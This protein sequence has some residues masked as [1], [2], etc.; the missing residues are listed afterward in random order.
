MDI[1]AA[2]II[3]AKAVLRAQETITVDRVAG[4]TL[5]GTALASTV[6]ETDIRLGGKTVI[7]TLSSASWVENI[8][9]DTTIKNALF[10]GFVADVENDIQWAKVVS[11]LKKTPGCVTKTSTNSI[12]ITL[13]KVYAYDITAAKQNISVTIP[14]GAAIGTT[15]NIQA[16]NA[17]SINSTPPTAAKI[18]EVKAATKI[19]KSGDIVDINVTFDTPVDVL[20]IQVDDTGIPAINLET[21]TIDRNAVYSSGTGTNVLTFSYTV[22]DGDSSLKLD[23]K[24]KDSLV[25]LGGNI[26][27]MGTS[28]KAV[29]TLPVPGS[30]GSLSDTSVV[31]VDAVAPKFNTS[32]PKKGTITE[33]TA[34][35]LINVNEKAT[36]YYVTRINDINN[37]PSVAQVITEGQ[38]ATLPTTMA[39]KLDIVGNIDGKLPLSGLTA[40]KDYTVYMVM[41]D[42]LGNTSSTVNAFNFSTLDTTP[43]EFS[44][45]DSLDPINYPIQ[46]VPTSD[47]L[48]NILIKTNET[49]K[50]YLIAVPNGSTPPTSTQVMAFHNAN[51]VPISQYLK[52]T[53]AITKDTQIILGVT[54]L[55]V[56][57][58]YDIYVVCVDAIGNFI[59]NPAKVTASTSQ[60]S[61]KNV[62]VDLAKKI[63]TNTTVQMQYSFDEQNWFDCTATNTNITYD[64]NAAILA[65]FIR[66]TKNIANTW[67]LQAVKR[68]D[69]ANIN[70][71]A[72]SYDIAAKT[73]T[74]TSTINLQYR[75]DGGAWN[76]LNA[77]GNASNVDF[78]PG[79]LEV[80]TAVTVS[81]LPSLP[82]T[83]YNIA[84]P[85]PAPN[86][87]YDDSE[88]IIIGLDSTYEFSIDGGLWKTIVVDGAFAGT[89]KVE[90][91]QKAT[92]DKL[93]SIAKVI[94]FT[95]G[96][97]KVVAVPAAANETSFMSSVTITF[98]ENTNKKA[99]TPKDIRDYFLVGTWSTTSGAIVASHYWGADS[100]FKAQWNTA[101]NVLTII[102]STM[103][104]STVKINDEVRIDGLAGIKNA[105]GTSS[106]YSPT[107]LLSGSFH[108]VPAIESVEAINKNGL[109]GFNN[110][111]QIIITFDQPTIA[112]VITKDNIDDWLEVIDSTGLINRTW[113]V[114]ADTDIAWNAEGT[115]LT[116]TFVDVTKTDITLKDKVTVSPLLG[117]T[118]ADE[119]TEACNSSSFISGSFTSTP[120]IVSVV[121]A[122]SGATNTKN[123]GDTITITFDQATNKK[124][125]KAYQLDT[126]LKLIAADGVTKHSWGAQDD[127]YIKWSADGKSVTIELRSTM[128]VTLAKGDTLYINATAGIKAADGGTAS[129]GGSFVITGGY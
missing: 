78:A 11:E 107:G 59:L 12:T 67:T 84:V 70:K 113:G 47:S 79:L 30:A 91:R 114:T 6:S 42:S 18:V 90:V 83:A 66:E 89:K 112:T 102:Y 126:W 54:G 115:Q 48:I 21:G 9:T 39:G 63:L 61:M 46:Q 58:D 14:T 60:L 100:D 128:G 87:G 19:Y 72:I 16:A 64:D 1:P 53:A 10:D 95:A 127:N 96:S 119:T 68:Q 32:Y 24:T 106:V 27:N 37:I 103:A 97:I 17:I 101:G 49:G 121:I 85:M 118:D 50:V 28:V 80:R 108:R 8:A 51:D 36:I 82:V 116:I 74:N 5:S 71:Y 129:C 15:I 111:D 124:Q 76:T 2:C 110:G 23:Y 65:I 26:F 45:A 62:G 99:L 93:P 105:A 86:L 25:L 13:P 120:K 40:F 31:L 123:I 20:G 4:A 44:K 33:L 88:N 34:D 43:P 104:N 69:E 81:E 92:K 94:N 109:I 3:G 117:L 7:I 35:I 52:A 122:N 98:E 77:A 57:T 41:V 75:I 125:I 29:L 73:I 55:T 22:K 38:N 56:S